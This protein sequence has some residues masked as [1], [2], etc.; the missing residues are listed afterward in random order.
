[1]NK[2][3]EFMEKIEILQLK[4]TIAKMNNSLEGYKSRLKLTG[5]RIH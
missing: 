4:I 3:I 5:E 1:M 2:E